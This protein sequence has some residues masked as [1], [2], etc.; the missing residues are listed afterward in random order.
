MVLLVDD[1]V[2]TDQL[3]VHVP[4]DHLKLEPG[5][6]FLFLVLVQTTPTVHWLL[7]P[8]VIKSAIGSIGIFGTI[9]VDVINFI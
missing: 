3:P 9:F 7:L 1:G 8:V 2:V 6:L 4:P 5:A